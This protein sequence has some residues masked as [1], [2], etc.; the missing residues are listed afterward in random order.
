MTSNAGTLNAMSTLPGASK[1]LDQNDFLKLLVTQIQFQNPMN[2]KS[3]TD[4]AA[5]MAQF[6]S[7]QQATQMSSSLTM[8]QANSL[9]GS[10][11][12]VQAGGKNAESGT[13]SGILL[14][15]G[16]PK[17]LVNGKVF[18]LSQITSVMPTLANPTGADAATG[19][20]T[21]EIVHGN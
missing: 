5:Q 21:R 20:Q 13:V 6:T 3:D 4:M 2:P 10:T 12:Q 7:L 14:D 18:N 15:G 19:D 9:V 11:V 17:I 1:A 16:T 8:L